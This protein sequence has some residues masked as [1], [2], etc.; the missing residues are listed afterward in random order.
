M[1]RRMAELSDET[2]RTRMDLKTWNRK[3]QQVESLSQPAMGA[4]ERVDLAQII[5]GIYR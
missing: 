3:D 5:H 4:R 2:A 1:I